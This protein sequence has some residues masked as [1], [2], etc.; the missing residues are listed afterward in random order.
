MT[1]RFKKIGRKPGQKPPKTA[2]SYFFK[3]FLVRFEKNKLEIENIFKQ[4][5]Y[6]PQKKDQ[7]TP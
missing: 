2:L 3:I 4:Y 6:I 1:I 5:K 7:N